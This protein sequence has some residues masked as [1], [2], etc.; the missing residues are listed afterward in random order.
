MPDYL[1]DKK[2][3]NV[4]IATNHVRV[5]LNIKKFGIPIRFPKGTEL[6]VSGVKMPRFYVLAAFA[7]D[8]A[9]TLRV[10]D[11]T[12]LLSLPPAFTPMYTALV[13]FMGRIEAKSY[14]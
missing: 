2:F 7:A 12:D 11:A 10:R 13:D 14:E 1:Y 3:G 8:K 6:H 4:H 5:A 9:M